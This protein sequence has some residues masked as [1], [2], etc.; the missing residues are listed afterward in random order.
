MF[1]TIVADPPWP[2]DNPD[3]P[4]ATKEHRP[5]SWDTACVGSAPRYGSMSMGDLKAMRVQAHAAPSAH[6]YLWTTNSFM[7]EAHDLARAWGFTPKTIL[8]WGKMKPDGS[9]SMKAGYYYRGATEHAVFAVR[10]VMRL[11]GDACPTLHLSPRLP[12]S[13]KP[14]WFYHMVETHSPGPY[15]EIFARRAR[16]GW[17]SWGNE[18]PDDAALA[19]IA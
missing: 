17:S 1:P 15:L 11:T 16:L 13:V 7:V 19:L 14:E 4:R 18:V 2:Y 10:G 8:T 5:N 6:L 9:P 12:H 3:G